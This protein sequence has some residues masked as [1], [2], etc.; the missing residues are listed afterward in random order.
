MALLASSSRSTTMF[1][2]PAPRAISMARLYFP[3]VLIKFAT[4]PWIPRRLLFACITVLTAL[5]NPSYSFSISVSRRMR[6]SRA[7]ASM[8]SFT[9]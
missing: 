4:G 6:L 5:E 9:L 1:W 3:S 2:S 8:V 7:P